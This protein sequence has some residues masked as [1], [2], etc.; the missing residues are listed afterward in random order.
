[1]DLE[2]KLD[3]ETPEGRMYQRIYLTVFV[4]FPIYAITHFYRV[5][6]TAPIRKLPESEIVSMWKIPSPGSFIFHSYLYGN[7][8]AVTFFPFY[9]PMVVTGMFVLSWF[10][11][12]TFVYRLLRRRKVEHKKALPNQANSADAKSRA[13]N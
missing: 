11:F 8:G 13:A 5:F 3:V 7:E 12:F 6:L 2:D 1:M 9:E 4:V 10:Y